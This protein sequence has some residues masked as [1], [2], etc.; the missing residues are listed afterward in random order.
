MGKIKS[1]QR[2]PGKR[3]GSDSLPDLT[4]RWYH[5]WSDPS[6]VKYN[7][8][9]AGVSFPRTSMTREDG[10]NG[11]TIWNTR[12]GHYVQL[13]QQQVDAVALA[14][15]KRVQRLDNP[16][17]G[18]GNIYIVGHPNYQPHDDNEPLANHIGMKLCPDGP[19]K[20]VR[21]PRDASVLDS[22]ALKAMDKLDPEQQRYIDLA[23]SRTAARNRAAKKAGIKVGN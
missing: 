13:N 15:V 16:T 21:S 4:R 7:V 3:S 8:V 2:T 20:T 10:D 12:K 6:C 5:V 9:L 18:A 22:L 19:P 17:T 14:L 23:Y 1:E 11:E